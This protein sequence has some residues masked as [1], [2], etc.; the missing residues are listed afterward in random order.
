[1]SNYDELVLVEGIAFQ[2]LCMHHLLPFHGVA[3]VAYL[4]GDSLIGLSSWP[5]VVELRP[6]PAV[7]GAAGYSGCGLARGEPASCEASGS[8]SKPSTSACRSVEYRSPAHEQLPRRCV[9]ESRMTRERG[10]S[11]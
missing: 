10:Q 4:P 1:M 11:S 7:A 5:R 2:S 3:H 8:C 6:R 9:A